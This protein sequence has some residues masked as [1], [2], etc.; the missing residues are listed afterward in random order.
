[1]APIHRVTKKEK[2]RID[3]E[4]KLNHHIPTILVD[5]LGDLSNIQFK[6][7]LTDFMSKYKG[8]NFDNIEQEYNFTKDF[9]C[10]LLES[11]FSNP[12]QGVIEKA[13]K[14]AIAETNFVD[15]A[16]ERFIHPFQDFL[17]GSIIIDKFYGQFQTWF[18]EELC[19]SKSTC[20]EA[21]WLLASV[22][23]DRTKPLRE[24]K[25]MIEYEEGE[26]V[27]EIPEKDEYI[28]ALSSLYFH[29]SEE[30][31]LESWVLDETENRISQI[32]REY[33]EA[34]NHGVKSSFSLLRHLQKAFGADAFNP[35][36]VEAA[37]AIAL[38]DSQ[39]HEQLLSAQILPLDIS[40]FPLP[41]LLLYCDAVQEWGREKRYN[42]EVRLVNLKVEED[43]VHCEIAFDQNEKARDKFEEIANVTRC[44]QSTEISFTFSP[45]VYVCL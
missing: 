34:D 41:C 29:L 15:A 2:A 3:E 25:N 12:F 22:F 23:H 9:I 44:F 11:A 45:R 39:L 5:L 32:L 7:V 20:V 18:S 31:T 6:D 1:M 40:R 24:L 8:T 10:R 38:H 37:L 14:L 26:V 42:P 35:S 33:A 17:L 4:L 28:H 19:K 16:R 27:V 36:Y 43:S 13:M 30:K 21:S